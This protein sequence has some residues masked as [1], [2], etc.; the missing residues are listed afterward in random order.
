MATRTPFAT[1]TPYSHKFGEASNIF[2]NKG[3]SLA[4]VSSLASITNGISFGNCKFGKYSIKAWQVFPVGESQKIPNNC[5][6]G[7]N[8]Q[9]CVQRPPLGHK[10]V[11]IWKRCLVKL[12][13]RLVIDDSNW[14]L[15]TGGRYSQVVVKLDLT[16]LAFAKFAKFETLAKQWSKE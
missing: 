9:T 6:F 14:L 10:K 7:K 16:V 2:L 12:I 5:H 8:S 1:I 15:L 11:A 13:F 3:L 4:D